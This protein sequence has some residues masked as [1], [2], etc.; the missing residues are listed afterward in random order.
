MTDQ[1]ILK[2]Q[3]LRTVIVGC[4]SLLVFANVGVDGAES[5]HY[6][7]RSD[8][9]SEG[10]IRNFQVL[11]ESN[12]IVTAMG[13]RKYHLVLSRPAFG[14]QSSWALGFVG[15][16]SQI[17]AGWG[18]VVYNQGFG[19]EKIRIRSLELLTP[20]QEDLLLIQHGL[21]EPEFEH[22]RA[23]ED[24]EGAGIEELD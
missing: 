1:V 18:E 17:C 10:T 16:T 6:A 12:L 8:C 3:L 7:A 21:K 23:P 24:V 20:D 11:D 22:P 19:A 13:K 14:L 15:V 4:F 9:I 2:K 5:D